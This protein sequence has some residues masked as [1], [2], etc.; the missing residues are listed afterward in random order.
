[1][2]IA[3]TAFDALIPQVQ[4]QSNRRNK[5]VGK[6]SP[7]LEKWALDGKFC[8]CVSREITM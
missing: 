6:R 5:S 2:S 4:T 3:F 7:K 1:M 8:A